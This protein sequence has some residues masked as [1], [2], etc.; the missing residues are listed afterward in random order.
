[1]NQ[2]R[3]IKVSVPN[4]IEKM[5]SNRIKHERE[6]VEAMTEYRQACQKLLTRLQEAAATCAEMDKGE[7]DLTPVGRLRRP[8]NCLEEYDE[9][10]SMLEFQ[11]DDELELTP[12]EFQKWVLDKW[13]WKQDFYASS[14]S[15]KRFL[16]E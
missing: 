5:K 9:V 16:D 6:F 10:I 15:N 8:T 14:V 2:E 7:V 3:K 4:L 13:H 1:M 11:L 12:E